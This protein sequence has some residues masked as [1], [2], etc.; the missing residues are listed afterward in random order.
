MFEK[1]KQGLKEAG[2]DAACERMAIGMNSFLSK[3]LG[4]YYSSIN[5]NDK[6]SHFTGKSLY[7]IAK[8]NYRESGLVASMEYLLEIIQ[9]KKPIYPSGVSNNSWSVEG[10]SSWLANLN[11]MKMHIACDDPRATEILDLVVFEIEKKLLSYNEN[12]KLEA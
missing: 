8:I 5:W 4:V 10:L 9:W 11:I 1:F 2:E 12:S 7:Q 3:N 6:V